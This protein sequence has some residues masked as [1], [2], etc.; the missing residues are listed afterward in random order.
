[1]ASY[2]EL[3]SVVQ[4]DRVGVIQLVREFI[5]GRGESFLVQRARRL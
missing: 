4:H 2:A 3:A 1:M 5:D